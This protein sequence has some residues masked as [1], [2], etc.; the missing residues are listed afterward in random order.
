MEVFASLLRAAQTVGEHRH[1][2]LRGE[3]LVKEG[4]SHDTVY[5]LVQGALVVSRV[6][7]TEP[8][9]LT[10][11][12]NPGTVIGEMVSLG[13]SV[14]T[15][16]ITASEASELIALTPPEFDSI[17]ATNP[18]I[19]TEFAH[20]TARRAEEDEL[21]DLLAG[22]FGLADDDTLETVLA[23]VEWHRLGRGD[24]LFN[25]GDGSDAVYFVVRG[26][27]LATRFD[28]DQGGQSRLAEIGQGE[29][30]GETGVLRIAPRNATITAL[31][32]TVLAALGEDDFYEL[33]EKRPRVMIE[34]CRR[35][36][37]RTQ[38]TRT[39]SPGTILAVVVIG[40]SRGDDVIDGI[41]ATLKQFGSVE[42]L[43]A[44]RV[45]SILGITDAAEEKGGLSDVRIARLLN[46]AEIASDHLIL[47]VGS[48]ESGWSRRCLEMADRVVIFIPADPDQLEQA[49]V[50]ALVGR[51]PSELRRIL[52]RVHRSA[53]SAPS[54]SARWFNRF[55]ADEMLH[56]VDGS[57]EDLARVARVVSG[58]ASAL[59]LSG[60]GGRGFAH[61]GVSRALN[62]LGIPIDMVGGASIGGVIAAAIADRKSV[63]E[64]I[65]W[66]T[67]HF[68]HVM[69]YT[70]PF[71][72][73]IKAGRIARSAETT[74]G[75]RSIEDLW[76]S[77]FCVSTDLTS[78]RPFVHRR[79]SVVKAIRA[80][81]AIPGVM[82]PVPDGDHLLVDGGVLNN[83]PLD[84]ARDLAPAGQV[85]AVDVAPPR[86]PGS[87]G[88]FGLSVSGWAA[89]KDRLGN[90]S[91]AY[92]GI[93]AILMRSMIV[94]SM[95]ERDNQVASSLADCYLHL[96]MRGVSIL[97]FAN[98][99][100]VAMRGYEAAM[101]ILEAWLK[102]SQD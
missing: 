90:Q 6:L 40:S 73:L 59:V 23:G 66:A 42:L 102:S 79:G 46:E 52:V 83:L 67:R 98:P 75:D 95:R 4:E 60:G 48:S 89:L 78:S 26:R 25:E 39:S 56:M 1:R 51:C 16:T 29:V 65:E 71:V 86:G 68:P 93:A 101:P 64:L 15:A 5:V 28:A 50:D 63:D 72:A 69:D 10:T 54:A 80:T 62:E 37:D 38:E 17:L 27:L 55:A 97:D 99:A 100:A 8:T 33:I 91:R 32:D 45:A 7:G 21:A 14:R 3:V 22:H 84:V 47:E 36:L 76:R 19:A 88:D 96:D 92:P 74:F 44:T 11:I 61:I 87:H 41:A 82:P 30:V 58:R 35:I 85:L 53:A 81:S 77:F 94:A 49:Q 34:V 43:G 31:R 13:E 24:V 20:L 12:T 70:I 18:E 2:L 9:I 57:H